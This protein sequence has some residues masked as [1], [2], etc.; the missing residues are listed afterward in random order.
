ME[1]NK[2][3]NSK[4]KRL[5]ALQLL[6]I[7]WEIFLIVIK[8][9]PQKQVLFSLCKTKNKKKSLSKYHP[10]NSEVRR[11]RDRKRDV[12]S[13]PGQHKSLMTCKAIN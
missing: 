5:D 9:M 1:N 12:L 8:I 11:H 7:K 10:A 2:E 13:Q 4:V 3:K 6:E